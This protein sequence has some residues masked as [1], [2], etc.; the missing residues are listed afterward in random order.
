MSDNIDVF[1]VTFE[2]TRCGM[3]AIETT[4][5]LFKALCGRSCGQCEHTI[6][7]LKRCKHI[8]GDPI[9]RPE[10]FFEE[11]PDPEPEK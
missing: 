10:D 11:R 8:F 2:C 7:R 4:T 3:T 6:L 5:D 1:E 9:P